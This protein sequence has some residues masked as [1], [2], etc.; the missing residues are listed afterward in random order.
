MEFSIGL[1]SNS[2]TGEREVV[3]IILQEKYNKHPEYMVFPF[4]IFQDKI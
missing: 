4:F 3:D 1:R 2:C